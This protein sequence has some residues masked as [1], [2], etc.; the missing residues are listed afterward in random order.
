MN[1][2]SFNVKK[3]AGGE[4]VARKCRFWTVTACAACGSWMILLALRDLQQ[5]ISNEGEEKKLQKET[6]DELSIKFQ[7]SH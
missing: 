5:R 6:H 7:F 2:C 4:D 3:H 1:K